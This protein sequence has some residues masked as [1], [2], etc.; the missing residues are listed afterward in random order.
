MLSLCC[1]N[2]RRGVYQFQLYCQDQ[3]HCSSITI[4]IVT[5]ILAAACHP[6]CLRA[7]IWSLYFS[8]SKSLFERYFYAATLILGHALL[9]SRAIDIRE[10]CLFYFTYLVIA[11]TTCNI[12]ACISKFSSDA[13]HRRLFRGRILPHERANLQITTERRGRS[14]L[15]APNRPFEVILYFSVSCVYLALQQISHVSVT[16]IG[17]ILRTVVKSAQDTAMTLREGGR[18]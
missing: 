11:L 13:L 2:Q 5:V 15:T 10:C 14:L 1:G 16:A 12:G 18:I 6:S 9:T 7:S 17:M 4:C 8:L 3:S